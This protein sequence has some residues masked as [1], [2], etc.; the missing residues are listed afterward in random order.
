MLWISITP[1]FRPDTL[2]P[3]LLCPGRL[4]R[5]VEFGLPDVD[6]RTQIFKIH[7]QKMNCERDIRFELLARLCP[8]C[9]GKNHLL[10][11]VF[12]HY[13]KGVLWHWFS[14]MSFSLRSWNKERVHRSWHVC[15]P[16]TEEIC[17]RERFPWCSGQ[18]HQGIQEIQCNTHVHGLQLIKLLWTI[19]FC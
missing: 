18:G 17:D 5:K 14:D 9:T 3:A 1:F 15:H 16:S 2:D 8:N 11:I 13:A 4:D 6:G 7:A 12:V 10:W 19:R